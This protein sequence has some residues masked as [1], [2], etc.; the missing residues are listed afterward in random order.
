MEISVSQITIAP[1]IAN[2]EGTQ[3]Y[4]AGVMISPVEFTNSGD[5]A[6]SCAS[7]L[8]LPVGLNVGVSAN[9]CAISGTPQQ[10]SSATAYTIIA[11]NSQGSDSATISIVVKSFFLRC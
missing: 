8:A 11:T 9:S 10:I 5:T 6:Q 2:I 1:S 3:T 4:Y 7:N